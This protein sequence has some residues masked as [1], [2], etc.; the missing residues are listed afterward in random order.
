M[1]DQGPIALFEGDVS[2]PSASN[3]HFVN[4]P[5]VRFD[6]GQELR[7]TVSNIIKLAAKEETAEGHGIPKE[8]PKEL[9]RKKRQQKQAEAAPSKKGYRKGQ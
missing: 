7:L 1:N 3:N 4:S 6:S 9:I 5:T 2:V 8:I